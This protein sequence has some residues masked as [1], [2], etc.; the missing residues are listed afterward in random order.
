[1]HL[2][3]AEQRLAE[4]R[5]IAHELAPAIDLLFSEPNPAPLKAALA[6]LGLIEDELRAPMTPAS[7]ALRAQLPG[8]LDGRTAVL[9]RNPLQ[10]D[11]SV[12][13]QG[14]PIRSMQ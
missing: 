2:A 6:Q 10:T 4:A 7:A 1:M 5:R 8:A 11:S 9:G 14:P 13:I 12:S 3:V